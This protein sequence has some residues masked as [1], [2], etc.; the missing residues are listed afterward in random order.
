M[1]IV[2][3]GIMASFLSMIVSIKRMII[4]FILFDLS[5]HIVILIVKGTHA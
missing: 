3:Q 1:N 4:D 2:S 5:A